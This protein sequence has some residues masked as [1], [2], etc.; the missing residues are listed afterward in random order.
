M[1]HYIFLRSSIVRPCTNPAAD[2]PALSKRP[3]KNVSTWR[4]FIE[5]STATIFTER[6]RVFGESGGA[7]GETRVGASGARPERGA[8][9]E[10]THRRKEDTM[11]VYIALTIITLI[12]ASFIQNAEYVGINRQP[13]RGGATRQQALNLCMAVCIFLLLTGVSACRI[14]VGNDYWV[15]RFQFNLIMQGRHVSYEPGFNLVVWVLQ[16]LFGYDNYLPVFA[17]FSVITCFF[18][19][20]AM[21]DQ[22]EDFAFALFLLLTGGYYFNSLNSVRYYLVLAMA[23]YSMKYVLRKEYGK[24]FFW[25]ALACLF[26]KSVLLVLVA[27]PI[28]QYLSDHKLKKWHYALGGIFLTSLIFGQGIYRELIFLIYPFYR[29]SAFDVAQL[30]W[31][32]IAKCVAV[33]ALCI[34]TW[35]TGFSKSREIRFGV[36]LNLMSLVG[37][38]CGSFIPEVSRVCYY[39]MI[40]QIFLIPSVLR[41]MEKGW[42]KNLC[43]AGVILA[44]VAYFGLLLKGMYAVDIRLL[45]YLNWIFN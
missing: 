29:D 4:G 40:S 14:A 43:Y 36:W 22:A 35:K 24:F 38:C 33:L 8:R 18:F 19:V 6:E 21:Y 41:R 1:T 12:L 31:A 17:F 2:T 26:H 9:G 27:Y 32:N 15:Y 10:R 25:V 34:I 42:F 39:M 28:A 23:L 3:L 13:W 20:K 30:S 45:P 11:A 37:Y 44:F 5:P 7:R 16:T